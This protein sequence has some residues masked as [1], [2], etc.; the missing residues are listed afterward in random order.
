[1]KQVRNNIIRIVRFSGLTLVACMVSLP[2][3][4]QASELERNQVQAAVDTWVRYETADARP[5]AV[6]V[7]MQPWYD[8]GKITAYIAHLEDGGFC[9]CG[10]DTRVLPVYFYSPKGVFDEEIEDYRYI[11]WEIGTRQAYLETAAQSSA[12]STAMIE[13]ALADRGGYWQQLIAG[14]PTPRAEADG[15]TGAAPITLTLNMTSMW[16]QR[17]PLNDLCPNLTPGQDE[18]VRVGCVAISMAQIMNYWQWPVTGVDIVSEE[19]DFR[20]RT[21]WDQTALPVNPRPDWVVPWTWSNGRL[22]W[23]SNNGGQLSMTG[24]WDWSLYREAQGINDADAAYLT[25]LETLW[26]RLPQDST[27]NEV[28]LTTVAYNYRIMPDNPVDPGPNPLGLGEWEV[29]E[30]CY[31]AG[32]SVKMNWGVNASGSSI[33]SAI[34]A[35]K[36]HFRYDPDGFVSSPLASELIE[37]IEWMRPSF[38]RGCRDE[39][40]GSGCH[41]WVAIGYNRAPPNNQFLVNLGWR[42]VS[43]GWYTLDDMPSNPPDPNGPFSLDQKQGIYAAPTNVRFVGATIS[44]DG[45]P[46]APYIDIDEA[47]IEAPNH[48]TLIFKAGSTNTF[49][50]LSLRLDRPMALKGHNIRIE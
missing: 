20:W 1:M 12:T 5:D 11:L 37:E 26:N 25:A 2:I 21:N 27:P 36:S 33:E 9:I 16:H 17:S 8:N 32:I 38:L 10:A 48:S 46:D 6:I 28:D 14:I 23:T 49:A 39:S 15:E 7:S 30:L 24:Y 50:G 35:L 3:F 22:A 45:S 31:H 41:V 18:R 4:I 43:D 44:G 47:L 19:Y 34:S 42:G 13:Q 29:A 40:D